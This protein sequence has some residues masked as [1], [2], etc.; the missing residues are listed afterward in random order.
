MD[1]LS[2]PGQLLRLPNL[3]KT[4]KCKHIHSAKNGFP[5]KKICL[6]LRKSLIN[7]RDTLA[8]SGLRNNCVVDLIQRLGGGRGKC[9]LIGTFYNAF[10]TEKCCISCGAMSGLSV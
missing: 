10:S 1:Y 7:R 5:A 9:M 4:W 2:K 3:K 8:A 6:Y